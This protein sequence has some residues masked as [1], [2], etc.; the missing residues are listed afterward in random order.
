M[1]LTKVPIAPDGDCVINA[2]LQQVHLHGVLLDGQLPNTLQLRSKIMDF[3]EQHAY[4][5]VAP[6]V[7][8]MYQALSETEEGNL[9]LKHRIDELPDAQKH[10]KLAELWANYVRYMREP[11]RW[12]GECE[13]GALAVILRVLIV[14]VEPMRIGSF[15]TG[16]RKSSTTDSKSG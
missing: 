13:L 10:T 12:L 9:I 1:G 15:P 7:T 4:D 2:V 5:E 11:K 14:S 16:G 8:L 6:G 3:M